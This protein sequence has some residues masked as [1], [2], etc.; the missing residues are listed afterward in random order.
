MIK[1]NPFTPQSGWEPKIFGGRDG[2]LA[3]FE[4]TLDEAAELRSNHIVVIG[5]WGI[6]KTSLLKQYKKISQSRG[7]PAS[8][9]SLTQSGTHA[10]PSDGIN[11]I[12]QE[13][14]FGFPLAK[15][16]SI[17]DKDY[18]SLKRAQKTKKKLEPQIRFAEFLLALFKSLSTK[19]AVVLLDDVQNLLAISEVVDIL[20]SVLSKDEIL[21]RTKYL[22]V[23]ASTPEGWAG[24]VDKH[25]PVGRFFRRR[26]NISFLTMDETEKIIHNSLLNTSVIFEKDVTEKIFSYTQ[27]HPY[28]LQLLC[29]HLYEAQIAGVVSLEQWDGA[30]AGTLRELGRD[31][32]DSLYN[33]SSD[34]EGD[35]LEILAEKNEPLSIGDLRSIMIVEKR[36][37]NF[38]VANIKNFLYRLR[39]K[40]LVRKHDDN[41][42]K[43]LDPMF[44]E[45]VRRMERKGEA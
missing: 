35:L 28:E 12:M 31:Y 25:D 29:S 4:K 3:D 9:C 5:E 37:K 10:K 40:G 30:F 22:F 14:T 21:S 2:Q 44:A 16:F 39:D 15:S 27:G 20:R 13:I 42:Y 26:E 33:R 7:Y 1:S 43:I 32:F 45:Y 24:F 38:P 18:G 19:L 11:L 36:A 6:G 23:L 17:E 8:Y 34:R 41:T